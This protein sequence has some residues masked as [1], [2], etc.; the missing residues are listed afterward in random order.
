V[1]IQSGLRMYWGRGDYA[2]DRSEKSELSKGQDSDRNVRSDVLDVD[3]DNEYGN[4][5]VEAKVVA[6]R[7]TRKV[8][9]ILVMSLHRS[10]PN[11]YQ[12]LASLFCYCKPRLD[13]KRTWSS[14]PY[15]LCVL[16]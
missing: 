15:S 13:L 16:Y 8:R 9:L 10:E 6:G 4:V 12:G 1:P 14:F 5:K 7:C 2:S 11:N 3:M